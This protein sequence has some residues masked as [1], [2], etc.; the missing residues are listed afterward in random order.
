MTYGLTQLLSATPRSFIAMNVIG[1]VLINAGITRVEDKMILS[2]LRARSEG[3]PYFM[4][5]AK[6]IDL[7]TTNFHLDDDNNY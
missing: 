7:N 3:L 5:K 1:T 2:N 4:N 6:V